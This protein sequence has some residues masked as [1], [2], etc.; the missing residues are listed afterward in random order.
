MIHI[1]RDGALCAA[2]GVSS[3]MTAAPLAEDGKPRTLLCRSCARAYVGA[4]ARGL[5]CRR[6]RTRQGSRGPRVHRFSVFGNT[7]EG[8][9]A[10]LMTL[11]RGALDANLQRGQVA[12]IYVTAR[13]GD[14]KPW[15]E[16]SWNALAHWEGSDFNLEGGRVPETGGSDDGD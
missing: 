3:A 13:A 2:A 5:G 11:L 6:K 10:Q 16:N 9:I 14:F 4:L 12:H 15:D 1:G 7:P 8:A